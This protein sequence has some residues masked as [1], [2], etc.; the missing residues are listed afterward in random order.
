MTIIKIQNSVNLD[1]FIEHL[2]DF[3]Y[4]DLTDSEKTIYKEIL[5]NLPNVTSTEEKK[6]IMDKLN[7]GASYLSQTVSKLEEKGVLIKKH[8]DIL[9]SNENIK[10]LVTIIVSKGSYKISLNKEFIIYNTN[11]KR[12]DSK[13]SSKS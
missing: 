4:P 8:R 13:S 10:K 2:I 6:F 11:E 3:T 5:L 12:D 1:T 9:I 7:V